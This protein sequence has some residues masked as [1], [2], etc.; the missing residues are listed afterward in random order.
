[1]DGARRIGDARCQ[2]GDVAPLDRGD[3]A[4]AAA[5]HVRALALDHLLGRREP[6]RRPPATATAAPSSPMS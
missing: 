3:E 5:V 1:V 4:H 6:R 2:R